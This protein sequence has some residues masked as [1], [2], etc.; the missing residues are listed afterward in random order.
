MIWKLLMFS[1][2]PAILV[3]LYL[4]VF[5]EDTLNR[6]IAAILVPTFVMNAFVFWV[7][8]KLRS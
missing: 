3:A 2:I 8:G 5:A 7:N 4:V 1:C 6:I